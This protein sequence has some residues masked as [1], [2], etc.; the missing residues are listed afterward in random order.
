MNTRA[1]SPGVSRYRSWTGSSASGRRRRSPARMTII[2]G[3]LVVTMKE[4]GRDVSQLLQPS[5]F[6]SLCFRVILMER[7]M[8][9]SL[10]QDES[11][12]V[13]W[14][15]RKTS[16]P[17][18]FMMT[19]KFPAVIVIRTE[20]DRFL[21]EPLDPIQERYLHILGLSEAVF[22]DP[23]VTCVQQSGHAAQPWEDSG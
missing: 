3:K 10:K 12:I 1:L 17:T 20:S 22:T 5:T 14:N 4:V 6:D 19:T 23:G 11:K 8:R 21:A 9:I 7:T 16:R 15:N 2:D 13:G 18:S